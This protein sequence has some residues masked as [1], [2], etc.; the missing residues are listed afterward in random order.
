M[1]WTHK[2]GGV[3]QLER[4]FLLLLICATAIGPA[5]AQPS[6]AA[7]S[8]RHH[9]AI[10]IGT[11]NT[12]AE[13]KD[14]VVTSNGVVLYRSDSDKQGIGGN[15]LMEGDWSFTNGV[16]RQSGILP[17]CRLFLGNTNWANYTV[18]LRGR[19]TGGQEGFF[20][21]FNCRDGDD[22]TWLNVAGWTNTLASLDRNTS[23]GRWGLCNRVAQAIKSNVW[24][25]VRVELRGE[26]IE[27]YVDSKRILT[28]DYSEP[29]PTETSKNNAELRAV[30]GDPVSRGA[31]GLGAYDTMVEFRN[32]L[33]TSNEEVLYQSDFEKKEGM[34]GWHTSGGSWSITNGVLCESKREI[35]CLA[36]FGNTNWAN[37][38]LTLQAR[39]TA[40]DEGFLIYFGRRD[41]GNY[42]EF[43][44]GG[45][46]DR[47][48]T[49][50]E[51][52]MGRVITVTG[53]RPLSIE[54]GPWY[55]IRVVLHG[56]RFD[57]YVNS[58]LVHSAVAQMVVSTTAEYLGSSRTPD[59]HNLRFK[60]GNRVFEG[61]LDRDR[62]GPPALEVGS[63]VRV[64][65]NLEPAGGPANPG[66]DEIGLEIFNPDD[67]ALL[68]PPSWWSWRRIWWLSGG[69]LTVASIAAIWMAMILRKN[70]SLT[71][72]KRELQRANDELERRVSERTADLAKANTELQHE[73]ALFRTLLDTAYDYI[74]FKD[75]DSR[76]V[77]CSV[78][79]GNW[80]GLTNGQFEGKTNFD[81][82]RE[83]QARTALAE[84][85][86]I[87]RTGQA[88]IGKVEKA[89]HPD[90][91][92]TWL[93]TT[94]MPWREA[95]GKIIGTVGISRDITSLKEAEAEL[96]RA[97]KQLIEASRA[98][99]MAEVATGVLHNVGNVLNSVNVSASMLTKSVRASK[100]K[101]VG[102]AADLMKDH[103]ADLGDFVTKDPQ[104]LRMPQFLS[105]LAEHLARE[106]A[107]AL[108]E[109]AGLQ[110][111]VE[112]IN[113]I[114]AMQQNY[115]TVAGVK[116][117]VNITELIEDVLR[118]T[119]TSIEHHGIKLAKELDTR[120]PEISVDRHKVLQILVN[121]IRNAKQACKNS[122]QPDKQLTVRA[123][124]T[125]SRLSISV[126]D[127]GVG[128]PKENLTRIF[129]H[130]FTTRENGH[131]FGLHSS[132]L[133]AKELGGKLLVSQRRTGKG[134]D[135][136]AGIEPEP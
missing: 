105:E 66:N 117:N 5:A 130:G 69:L 50:Q 110:K 87:I 53:Q 9:G 111:N 136:H 94:K 57:C 42:N 91:R 10:G 24:Y 74:Y 6:G 72:A 52:L 124:A 115:A 120:L 15:F 62:G 113:E 89:V 123:R 103:A 112:H 56:N 2:N 13:F 67:I 93:M 16:F 76:F 116:S 79:M 102:R 30:L 77:R 40:G 134:R 41:D 118:L 36:T 88:L 86:E 80:P 35:N 47:Y 90:G 45:S 133:A 132:A 28:A 84:E 37:Y 46:G 55:D 96:K 119:E 104:G 98:S 97:Q 64:T 60:S 19:K 126:I 114:V 127:N 25:D 43:N 65:G 128:I 3:A 32:I 122:P 27:C 14:I 31:I 107:Q 8:E 99:G 26:R 39:K 34:E 70:R 68:N 109:L 100:V 61:S 44:V 101:L 22:W 75:L 23:A 71:V 12:A 63:M 73:Q 1:I 54:T 85:Q 11:W 38:T 29:P 83:E 81:V 135:V 92:I 49:I 20:V 121:L 78:S 51:C 21:Y 82:Y 108:E 33:V 95:D 7:G 18:S 48:A 125:D 131:G 17:Q 4:R 106:Q 59:G 58:E 129:A